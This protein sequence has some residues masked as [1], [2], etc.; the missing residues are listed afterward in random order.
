MARVYTSRLLTE[1]TALLVVA[2]GLDHLVEEGVDLALVIPVSELR[3]C[4][5]LVRDVSRGQHATILR[6]AV[7]HC[8]GLNYSFLR[9]LLQFF[10]SG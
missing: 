4:E 8:A 2:Q 1:P 6:L 9:P 7:H 5:A 3:W 10:P